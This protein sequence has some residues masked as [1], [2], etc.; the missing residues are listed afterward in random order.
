MP[1]GLEKNSWLWVKNLRPSE[2]IGNDEIPLC[3]PF[4]WCSKA[5]SA[6]NL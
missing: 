5:K 2:N 1:I 6:G 3:L 4:L